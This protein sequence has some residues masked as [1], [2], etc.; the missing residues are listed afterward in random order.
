MTRAPVLNLAI[1]LEMSSEINAPPKPITSENMASAVKSS[2]L[3]V[4]K[5][6]T[7][8]MRVVINNTAMTATLVRISSMTRFIVWGSPLKN[9]H[10]TRQ[11]AYSSW[12]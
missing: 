10:L 1:G 12:V 11:A 6:S 5:R 2:P 7:P 4:K 9:A 3:A 8:K